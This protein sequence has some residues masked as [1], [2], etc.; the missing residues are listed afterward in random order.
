[1]CRIA[2]ILSQQHPL[3]ALQVSITNICAALQ[4]G[5]PDDEGIWSDETAGLVLGHRRLSLLDL[6]S[7]G[8]QPMLYQD[9]YVISFNG[10]IYN[11]QQLRSELQQLGHQFRTQTDTEVILAAYEQWGTQ[12]FARLEGM[13]AF[14]LWDKTDQTLLLVRDRSGIKPLYYIHTADGIAFASE[15]KVF[16]YLPQPPAN[17]PNWPVLMLAYGH[18]PEPVTTYQHVVPLPKGFFLRYQQGHISLQSFGFYSFSSSEDTKATAAQNIAA[19]LRTAVKNHLIADAP[20]GVFLSGGID[21]GILF[22]LAAEQKKQGLNSLS[23]Y[24][25]EEKYSEK[26]YQDLLL[27]QVNCQ[28]NQYKLEGNEF[29]ETL[30]KILHDMDLPSCDGINTWFI[31]KYAKEQGLK[32]VLSG[33]GADELLGGYP[34]FKRL[35]LAALVQQSP[36]LALGSKLI[37]GRKL[38][39]LNYLQMEGISGLYLFLRG[40]FAPTDIA[41]QLG[42][43][44]KEVWDILQSAPVLPDIQ[45]LHPQNQASWMETNLYMQ[46]QLLRDADV[47]SMAHGIE[48]RVPF[49]DHAFQSYCMSLGPAIKYDTA[50]PKGLLIEAF[51]KELPE[52]VWNRPKMGFSFPFTE[53]FAESSFVKETMNEGSEL[54]QKN[55][56]QFLTGD[57]HWSQLLSLMIIQ[58]QHPVYA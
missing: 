54:Q 43:T 39:R 28:R 10:E 26:T 32:A 1:M 27:Q 53:W 19:L 18:L 3:Q 46:N 9:R 22:L 47:M 52:P 4:H 35:K 55:Y 15:T 21:S 33:I 58:Q 41:H 17:N 14:A 50:L 25:S 36:N 40:H 51:K 8:H 38:S 45:R 42:A 6:S 12:S 49:L 48:I 5:G 24:F 13:F 30:P 16:Q 31:S 56:Q 37:R 29:L 20:I 11:F 44:E 23:L 2:G 7:A 57:L 34:S